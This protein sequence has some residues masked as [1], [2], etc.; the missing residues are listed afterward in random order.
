MKIALFAV[1]L[2]LGQTVNI[3]DRSPLT[4]RE[5]VEV[6]T[7]YDIRHAPG[8]P[9]QDWYGM[10]EFDSRR[11][12]MVTDPDL[13]QRR[14]ITLHELW[15]AVLRLRGDDGFGD[16]ELIEKLT[17]SEYKRMFGR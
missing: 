4:E 15:H 5:I 13:A 6:M 8:I 14:K 12:T 3:A 7:D 16:E 1:S 11:I 10:T 9:K 17:D 2:L